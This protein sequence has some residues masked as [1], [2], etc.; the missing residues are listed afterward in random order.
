MCL[1]NPLIYIKATGTYHILLEKN[2]DSSCLLSKREEKG[3]KKYTL[4]LLYS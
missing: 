3:N 2:T 4:E 1:G